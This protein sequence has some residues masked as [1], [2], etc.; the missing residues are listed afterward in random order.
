MAGYARPEL[1]VDTDWLA[2]HLDDPNVRVVDADYPLSFA[3][4][5][6]PGA[7]G[8]L[9]PNIYLK[10]AD[11]ETFMMEDATFAQTMERMGIGDDTTVVVYD[12]HQSLYAARFWWMLSVHG[13]RDVR[14]LNGGW[15]SWIAESRPVSL[16]PAA[17]RSVTLTPRRNDVIRATCDLVRDAIGR[18]DSVILDVR[19]D[20]EWTGANDRGNKRRGHVPGAVHLEWVNFMTND[21]R[22][23]FK[24]ADDLRTMLNERGVTPDKNV[25]TY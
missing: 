17:P 25:Y 13:H 21:D 14:I 1:L 16:K 9:G 15:H 4:A 10:T 23:V 12:S 19:T 8:H 6:I 18:S 24:S 11:G 2:T 20:A 3:R 22:V 5:H 7:V